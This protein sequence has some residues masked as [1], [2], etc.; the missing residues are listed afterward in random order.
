MT[1]GGRAAQCA[2]LV[3][4]AGV[5]AEAEKATTEREGGTE[6]E[7]ERCWREK[8]RGREERKMLL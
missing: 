8:E 3:C 2:A 7:G 5:S 1:E 6:R 4:K